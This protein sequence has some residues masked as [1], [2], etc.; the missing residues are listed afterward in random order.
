[1]DN[2]SHAPRVAPPSPAAIA[3]AALTSAVGVRPDALGERLELVVVPVLYAAQYATRLLLA[4]AVPQLS[5]GWLSWQGVAAYV[6]LFWPI[7]GGLLLLVAA[8]QLAAD[9][10]STKRAARRLLA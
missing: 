10:G 9:A 5:G 7:N 2:R 6:L 4:L 3:G 1:M 8:A